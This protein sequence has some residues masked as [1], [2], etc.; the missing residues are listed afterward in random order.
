MESEEQNKTNDVKE[1]VYDR[2]HPRSGRVLG[3]FILI[4]VGLILFL[5]KM[6]CYF[7]DWVF[8]WKMLLIVIGFYVGARHVFRGTGWLIP[9]II[10]G[11]FLAEDLIPGFAIGQF[12]WP[13]VIVVIGL[14]MIFRPKRMDYAHRWERKWK[15]RYRHQHD[16]RKYASGYDTFNSA[17]DRMDAVVV[18]GSEKKNIISKDFKGGEMTCVF[19][20]AEINLTQADINGKVILEINQVFGGTKLIIPPHWRIQPETV[21]FMGNIEDRR[22]NTKD[23]DPNKILVLRGSSVF[24]AIHISSY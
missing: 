10:G 16:W 5:D 9:I 7:P 13:I 21:T 4:G 6:G 22:M 20:G 23:S 8:T 17:E 18:F 15:R 2:H 3:G 12:V 1:T 11:L 14:F 19:G 24:G